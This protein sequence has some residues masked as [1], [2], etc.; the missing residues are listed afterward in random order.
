MAVELLDQM[1]VRDRP[2][3]VRGFLNSLK[4]I[5]PAHI[6]RIFSELVGYD[7]TEDLQRIE[8]PTPVLTSEND[9]FIPDYCGPYIQRNLK[10]AQLKT[11][12]GCGH[13]PYLQNPKQFNTILGTF[14]D[15]S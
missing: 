13:L 9:R 11:I 6:R 5:E 12:M 8:C 10:H 14:L 1:G 2:V 15:A 7:Q 4:A 3:I